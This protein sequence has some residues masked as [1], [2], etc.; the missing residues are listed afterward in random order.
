MISEIKRGDKVKCLFCGKTIE[1]NKKTFLLDFDGEYVLCPY[2]K[3]AGDSIY[4]H[5]KGEKV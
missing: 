4:Y 1:I 3:R 2:C 5:L